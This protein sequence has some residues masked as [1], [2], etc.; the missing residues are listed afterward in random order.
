MKLHKLR[1]SDLRVRWRI[2]SKS[3]S[4]GL[5]VLD[6]LRLRHFACRRDAAFELTRTI[7]FFIGPSSTTFYRQAKCCEMQGHWL[8]FPFA[9]VALP[10]HEGMLTTLHRKVSSMT[11]AF[12]SRGRTP[13]LSH[14]AVPSSKDW[15]GELSQ[16]HP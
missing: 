16:R 8:S 5:A 12:L 10:C 9:Y 7:A 15:M 6:Q 1:S 14:F 3:T 4:M 2:G 13:N 11:K